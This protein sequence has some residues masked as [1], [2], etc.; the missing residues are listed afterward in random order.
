MKTVKQESI[1]EE[2]LGLHNSIIIVHGSGLMQYM[3]KIRV[4]IA[5]QNQTFTGTSCIQ[6]IV[7]FQYPHLLV[8]C[9]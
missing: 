9:L 6:D 8:D 3:S 7:L 5:L 2:K 4:D 1:L